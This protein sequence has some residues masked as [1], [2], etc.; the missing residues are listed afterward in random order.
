[1]TDGDSWQRDKAALLERLAI[2]GGQGAPA[3]SR[4][5]LSPE[6]AAAEIRRLTP[7]YREWLNRHGFDGADD[8]SRHNQTV[9]AR[10]MARYRL[11]LAERG[12]CLFGL[13]GRGKTW[14]MSRFALWSRCSDFWTA[15]Q[16]VDDAKHRGTILADLERPR[17]HLIG[18][19]TVWPDCII[20]EIG[21]ESRLVDYGHAE[22]LIARLVAS[23]D[24]LY[25]E[26]GMLM[27]ATSNLAEVD[28]RERYG[29]RT[30]SRL[31][32]M[33]WIVQFQGEDRRMQQQEGR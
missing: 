10:Y 12:L 30:W 26:S 8:G 28:F 13:N 17:Q 7:R 33:C 4:P 29:E 15:S 1:M 5:S 20:D 6:Q 22:E 16:I 14:A 21:A 9:I 2:D 3:T 25:T 24:R 23:R 27:H 11:G 18:G 32:G 19:E 31:N